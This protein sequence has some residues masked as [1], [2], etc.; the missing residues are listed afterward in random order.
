[1]PRLPSFRNPFA[2]RDNYEDLAD[3]AGSLIDPRPFVQGAYWSATHPRERLTQGGQMA[4]PL[5][6]RYAP[7]TPGLRAESLQKGDD[8]MEL[9]MEFDEFADTTKIGGMAEPFHQDFGPGHRAYNLRNEKDEIVAS[10][11]RRA[12]PGFQ[13]DRKGHAFV[14]HMWIRE[15]YRKTPAIFDMYNLLSRGGKT[16]IHADFANKRLGEV[17]ARRF[18]PERQKVLDKVAKVKAPPKPKKPTQ[19]DRD[20]R[21]LRVEA[22]SGMMGRQQLVNRDIGHPLTPVRRP[23]PP[24]PARVRIQSLREQQTALGNELRARRRGGV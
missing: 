9:L 6:G 7:K 16:P 23:P 11:S 18:N 20:I 12:Y 5:G 4:Y 15:D 17:V 10:A 24:R 8:T 14:P 22:E 19:L 13:E 1:M 3:V 21:Q 2:S